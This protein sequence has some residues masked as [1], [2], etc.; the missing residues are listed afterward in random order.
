MVLASEQ[1]EARR[2]LV[3][4]A[5]I[6]KNNGIPLTE[7]KRSH[8]VQETCLAYDLNLDILN[9]ISNWVWFPVKG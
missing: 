7:W 4:S 1:I 5:R 9:H 8:V 3:I 6:A 2:I